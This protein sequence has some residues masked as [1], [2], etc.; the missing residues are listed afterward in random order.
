M[1]EKYWGEKKPPAKKGTQTDGN[2]PEKFISVHENKIYYYANVNRESAVE[3]NKKIGE[4]ESKS[5]TMSKTLD[6]DTPSIK[7]LINSGGGS[8]TA[9]IS[10]M[11][12]ILRCKVPVHTYVDGFCASAATFLSVVGEKRFMSRNSYMLIHQLSTNF[13]GKYSEFEDEKQNLDLMMTTIKNVYREYTEVP[14]KKIDEILKHDLMWDAETCKT[15][16]L[17]DEII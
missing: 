15:L 4:L 11:D 14:M 13:W 17:I 3:L 9:G 12:T 6:I 1:D 7:V 16:G 10:S 5:L 2:K 8:I